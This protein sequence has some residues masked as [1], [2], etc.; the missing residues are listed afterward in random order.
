MANNIYSFALHR[1]IRAEERRAP[2]Q[3]LFA[4]RGRERIQSP[5]C[6]S[7]TC[8]QVRSCGAEPRA[9]P[10]LHQPLL[11]LD[12]KPPSS[13]WHSWKGRRNGGRMGEEQQGRQILEI[14]FE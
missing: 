14:L 6:W 8:A 12:T 9:P 10:A 13:L 4:E 11:R 3:E 5:P 2:G 1:E 7:L